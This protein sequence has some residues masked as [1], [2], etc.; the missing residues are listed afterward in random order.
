MGEVYDVLNYHITVHFV[1]NYCNTV[2]KYRQHS[3]FYLYILFFRH[4]WLSD[5]KYRPTF[6]QI[7]EIQSQK[8]KNTKYCHMV[9][10][11]SMAITLLPL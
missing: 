11:H 9:H 3:I 1:E 5:T 2:I 8:L 10:P 6:I 7:T 4:R